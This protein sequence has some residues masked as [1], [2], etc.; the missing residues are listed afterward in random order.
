MVN[1]FDVA[2]STNLLT[3]YQAKHL[4]TRFPKF[5]LRLMSLTQSSPSGV[6]TFG[7]ILFKQLE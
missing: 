2:V 3:N 4:V 5:A 7:S 6:N 1:P